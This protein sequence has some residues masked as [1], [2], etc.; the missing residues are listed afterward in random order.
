MPPANAVTMTANGP[1]RSSSCRIV[2]G[3]K[4]LSGSVSRDFVCV[5]IERAIAANAPEAR[6]SAAVR[7]LSR[8]RLSATLIVNGRTLPEQNFAIMDREL[9]PDAIRRFAQ[10]L[11]AVVAQAGKR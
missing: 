2:A 10:S 3:E 4:F 7:A 5:E 8:S 6:Y 1:G 9:N 11:A